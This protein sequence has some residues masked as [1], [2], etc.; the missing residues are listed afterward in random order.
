[1]LILYGVPQS[2]I[3][4]PLLSLCIFHAS[5]VPVIQENGWERNKG[6]ER[7]A[8]FLDVICRGFLT[9]KKVPCWFLLLDISSLISSIFKLYHQINL[10]SNV[11]HIKFK[12]SVLNHCVKCTMLSDI[13]LFRPKTWEQPMMITK[14]IKFGLHVFHVK[15]GVM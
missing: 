13:D 2:S 10:V 5:T 4:G 15:F 1:M 6:R 12:F 7:E 8:K 3:L 14:N 9:E 11:S